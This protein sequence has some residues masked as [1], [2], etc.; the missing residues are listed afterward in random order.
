[1]IED[2]IYNFLVG[3]DMY[4]PPE[5]AVNAAKRVKKWMEEGK[6]V[7]WG[8]PVGWARMRDL[9][10]GKKVSLKTVKRM[11]AFARHLPNYEKAIKDPKY[12]KEPWKS[13]VICAVL[14]WGGVGGIE[15]A[16]RISE[17]NK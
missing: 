11:A 14:G 10:A 16:K 7:K 17:K 2:D 15:W 9:A 8:T 12:K 13:K 6:A 4:S 5:S 1:M 3:E